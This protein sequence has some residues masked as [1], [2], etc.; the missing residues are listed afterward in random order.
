VVS[1]KKDHSVV[2]DVDDA[3]QSHVL[4]AI[5]ASYPDHAVV[6]EETV[7]VPEVHAGLKDAR[8]VWVIDPVD[9]TR[10][11]AAGFPVFA[12]AIGVLDRGVL[13]GVVREHARGDLY[14]LEPAA[15][16]RATANPFT[17]MNTQSIPTFCWDSPP[18][19]TPSLSPWC[20]TGP[21]SA[22]TCFATWVRRRRT[23]PWWLPARWRAHSVGG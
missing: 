10:N 11:Y 23:S 19:R 16:R 15:G 20:S 5:S 7:A 1:H 9:G 2:T 13:Q 18:A 4:S 17:Y 14:A 12:T 6:A 8:Y 22:V 3:A 21:P